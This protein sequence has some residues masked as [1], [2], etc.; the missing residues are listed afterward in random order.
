[1]AGA[2]KVDVTDRSAGPVHDPLHVKA[3]VLRSGDTTVVLVT[4]DAVAIGEIG[5]VGNEFLPTLRKQ[6]LEEFLVPSEHVLVNASHCHGVVRPD[7]GELTVQ[8]VRE[9]FGHLAPAKVGAGTAQENR[10]SENRRLHMKDG[11]EVDMRRAYALPPDEAVAGVG[12]IDPEVGLLRVDHEDGR[13]LAVL[14]NFACHPIMNPPQVGNSADYPGYAS[15][16]IEENVGSGAVAFFLQGCAGDIN[17]VR[18][19]E[20]QQPPDAEPLGNLLGLTVLNAWRAITTQDVDN[21]RVLH[22][23]VNLPRGEDLEQRITAIQQQ[24][25]DLLQSL[26]PTD[27]NFKSFLPLL[28]QHRL[29]PEAPSNHLQ[30]YLHDNM[31]ERDSLQTL[32][33]ANRGYVDAYLGNIY[34]MEQLTRLNV[35]LA[36]LKQHLAQNKAAQSPTVEAEISILRVGDFHLLT[37]PGEPT[38]EIGLKLKSIAPA[39]LTFVAGY[40][41]G[42]IYYT[43]TAKQ[44]QN[45]GGAQ[46][47]SDCLLAPEWEQLF[48]DRVAQ[49]LKKL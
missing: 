13:P 27:I 12:P 26:Q 37:L 28:L 48:Y 18:Y 42:Y 35:N 43:P 34:V 2:A 1:M 49:L 9:A 25:L 30:G 41:N 17:P 32:D 44:L 20:V 3:L 24:Q 38:V 33:N 8:A 31:V 21:L 46:E 23:V 45:S 39:P 15:R 7:V 5:P 16:V 22:E 6:L 36:L 47:D 14:Y 4:V 19:K 10:I 29:W 11:S 40:T